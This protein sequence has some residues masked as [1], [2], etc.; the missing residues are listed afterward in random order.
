MKST[1]GREIK[2]SCPPLFSWVTVRAVQNPMLGFAYIDREAGPS[3]K[4]TPLQGQAT[5]ED[6]KRAVE[7][8]LVTV[9][10]GSFPFTVLTGDEIASLCLPSAPPWYLEF[11][12]DGTYGLFEN[13]AGPSYRSS[14]PAYLKV[15]PTGASTVRAIPVGGVPL[16][17]DVKKPTFTG[18]VL[19]LLGKTPDTGS[20]ADTPRRQPHPVP[21]ETL[22]E[23]TERGRLIAQLDRIA[24]WGTDAVNAISPDTRL[25]GYYIPYRHDDRWCIAFGRM[26]EDGTAFRT[27]YEAVGSGPYGW[28]FD[29]AVCDP[30]REDRGWLCSAANAITLSLRQPVFSSAVEAYNCVVVPESD[31]SNSVYWYPGS[32]TPGIAL[33]GADFRVAVSTTGEATVETYHNTLLRSEPG[34]D[35]LAHTHVLVQHPVPIDVAYVLMRRPPGTSLIICEHWSYFVDRDGTIVALDLD[36]NAAIDGQLVEVIEDAIRSAKEAAI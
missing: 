31:G 30:P 36:R 15:T 19:R 25:L 17:D 29:V 11:F 2:A 28:P 21:R 16:L 34:G 5:L 20:E 6:A 26:A 9:R 22:A 8:P 24:A 13:L 23:I 33:L 1:E 32:R 10:M 35:I 12:D 7:S 3:V 27:A 18:R 4:G 14:L